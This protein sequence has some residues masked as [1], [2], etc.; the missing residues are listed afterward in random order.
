M[1]LNR[2]ANR[3]STTGRARVGPVRDRIERARPGLGTLVR[4]GVE[5]CEPPIA[6][7]AIDAAFAE[8]DRLHALLGFHDA[9]S[10]VSRLNRMAAVGVPTRVDRDTVVALQHAMQVAQAS[11]GAFDITIA[12]EAV[13]AGR[14]PRPDGAPAPDPAARWTDV[15]VIDDQ[16]VV[17]DRPLWIDLGGIA[18][19]L[20]VDRAFAALQR[21]C[22]GLQRCNLRVDAGGD[23]R[24]AGAPSQRVWLDV[25]GHAAD[26]VPQIDI[27]DAS[28]ASSGPLR[29]RP[30]AVDAHWDGRTRAATRTDAFAA[31][32]AAECVIADALTKVV[33]ARGA[34]S[35]A[36]LCHFGATAWLHLPGKG[37]QSLGVTTWGSRRE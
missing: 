1:S 32:V 2:V 24:V 37:W 18:K 30:T 20:A 10:D 36:A 17:F 11:D 22:A 31:V 21:A 16:H 8:I 13:M 3:P 14:L 9:G 5:G 19:G 12:P 34:A 7:R 28:L 25:P 15:R 35:H 4:I 27:Q 29:H 6:D 26:S 23:L 33:L